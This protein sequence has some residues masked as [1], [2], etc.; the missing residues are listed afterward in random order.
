MDPIGTVISTF[1]GPSSVK[2][3]FVINTAG[4]P[5]RKNQFIM[6]DTEEGRMMARV[7]DIFKSNRYFMRA[8][9][10]REYERSGSNMTEIFPTQR[11]EYLIAEA[12]P[13]GVYAMEREHRTSFPP[14]PGTKVFLADSQML[15]KFL[16]FDQSKGVYLGNVEHHNLDVKLNL[17]R[18][19]QKHLAILAMSGAGK[20]YLTSVMIEELL[21][22][23][24]QHGKIAV[25]VIDTHGE[26][27][28]FGSD[29]KYTTKTMVIEGK[30]IKFGVPNLGAGDIAELAPSISSAQ[31]RELERVIKDVR[32]N[33]QDYNLNAI[34]DAI[35][36]DE[37][38]KQATK[39]VLL[40][41]LY[42]LHHTGLFANHDYPG[43]KKLAS[44]GK[45]TIIDISGM[46]S[47]RQRQIL[48]TSLARKLFNA[49]FTNGIPPFVFIVE[50]AHN[51]APE[52]KNREDALSKGIIQ[53]I[54]REGRKFHASL[55]L[56]SQRPVQLSTTA[57]SQCNTHI[58]LRVTNPYDLKHIG[59]SSEGITS[60]VQDTI[61]SLRVGEALIVGEAVN[62]P[63]FVKI[64]KRRSKAS[65]RGIPLEQAAVEYAAKQKKRSEDA[66]AFS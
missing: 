44:A 36:A 27:I 53:K 51:F 62:Y 3:S 22:R 18:F 48:V 58:I 59:E 15:S 4:L 29:E 61:T 39:E 63:I 45:A 21:D 43:L 41:I 47:Q 25:I 40:S 11:W 13:L 55:C 9:T 20:S 50:E 42:Q 10:V 2:F 54:A 52:G 26:Y 12:K 6:L 23:D 28:G 56:I 31:R 1:D 32:K 30:D 24:D 57:L 37:L 17:T 64:R 38:I 16:G 66:E 14:S 7:M 34:A 35:A 46:T 8:E 5:V 19:L 49:R 60:D 33:N 65:E